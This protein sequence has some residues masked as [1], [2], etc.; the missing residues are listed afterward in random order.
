[1]TT[2]TF[3]VDCSGARRRALDERRQ[4]RG[5]D[6]KRAAYQVQLQGRAFFFFKGVRFV[7][8]CWIIAE[9][10]GSGCNQILGRYATAEEA[11]RAWCVPIISLPS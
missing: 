5:R 7:C 3:V 10:W 4:E 1:M 11:A 6:G 8:N 9:L 2:P